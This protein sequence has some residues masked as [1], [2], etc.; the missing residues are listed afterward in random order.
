MALMEV[1][2]RQLEYDKVIQLAKQVIELDESN[3]LAYKRM[4]A[5]YHALKRYPEALSSLESAFKLE[6][7]VEA[8]KT[9]RSY[10]NA[11]AAF[12]RRA[13]REAVAVKPARPARTAALSP[14]DIERLYDSGVE[15]YSRGQ[16]SDA[17]AAFR[18]ILEADPNNLSARR[19]LRRVEAEQIQSGDKR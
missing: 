16:L 9:L 19:A 2:F 12:I 15:Y 11:L 8:R 18:Q 4:G 10:I 17:A 5:A 3:V 6:K 13:S 7:D 14:R 1:A